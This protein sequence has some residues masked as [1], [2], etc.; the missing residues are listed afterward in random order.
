M[1]G[2]DCG[3]RRFAA[4]TTGA[5]LSR[6]QKHLGLWCDS[7]P[8][9]FRVPQERL[10]KIAHGS[11]RRLGAALYS[12]NTL[13][14]VTGQAMSMVV[15]GRPASLYTQAMVATISASEK[16][17]QSVVDLLLDSSNESLGRDV[18]LDAPH[19]HH[20]WRKARHYNVR[21]TSGASDASSPA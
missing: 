21:L 17:G 5:W 9:T 14:T 8:A 20:P 15:A 2:W 11:R 7:V 18:G 16:S 13:Q 6:A 10:D 12:F 4:G 19:D 3:V 1:R